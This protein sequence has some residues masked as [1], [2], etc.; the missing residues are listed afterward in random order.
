MP[1]EPLV[2]LELDDIYF[3][4]LLRVLLDDAGE[5][6]RL[7]MAWAKAA[8]LVPEFMTKLSLIR[9]QPHGDEETCR[10]HVAEVLLTEAELMALQDYFDSESPMG[11]YFQMAIDSARAYKFVEGLEKD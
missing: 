1:S 9:R 7:E 3:A 5:D 10:C 6:A 4:D 11:T 8:A 2:K